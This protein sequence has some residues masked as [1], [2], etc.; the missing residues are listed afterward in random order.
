LG[1]ALSSRLTAKEIPLSA[2]PSYYTQLEPVT[3]KIN[4]REFWLGTKRLPSNI[5]VDGASIAI[6]VKNRR[7]PCFLA[8]D[9]SF[10]SVMEE[11]YQRVKTKT[12]RSCRGRN[13]AVS[14]RNES[15]NFILPYR[16][17]SKRLTSSC[18]K[19]CTKPIA[20]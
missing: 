1:R 6:L 5:E 14:A 13:T 20:T 17:A 15:G 10:L 8:K 11:L 4:Q 9:N 19:V 18:S 12:E 3:E 7:L 16:L 2:S